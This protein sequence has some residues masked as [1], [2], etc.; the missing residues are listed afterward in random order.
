MESE[1]AGITTTCFFDSLF[2][3]YSSNGGVRARALLFSFLSVASLAR[4]LDLP[5]H[6]HYPR[7]GVT[8]NSDKVNWA[9][10]SDEFRR[11]DAFRLDLLLLFGAKIDNNDA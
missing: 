1:T 10:E 2:K 6:Y 4:S 7:R 5:P 8:A 3:V 9:N 11:S